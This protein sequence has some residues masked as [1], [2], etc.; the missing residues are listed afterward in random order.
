MEKVVIGV[1]TSKYTFAFIS[2]AVVMGV[3]VYSVASIYKSIFNS[4]NITKNIPKLKPD[5][6]HLH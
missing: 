5:P 2:G 3:C 1:L 4:P 6:R